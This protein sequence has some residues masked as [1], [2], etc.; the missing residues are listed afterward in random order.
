MKVLFNVVG[1]LALL[2]AILGVF[3]PLL[4]TTPFLLLASACYLRGSKR[5]HTWLLQ[6][7]VLGKV[8]SD[9]QQH[10]VIPRRAKVMA[11]LL[12]WPSIAFSIYKVQKWPVTIFL[13][14]IGIV[15]TVYLIRLPSKQSDGGPD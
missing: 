9:Y 13:I 12:L 3:L 2:L 7:P 10:R 15:V 8:L 5:M 1:T 11:I 6:A 14:A 4:P